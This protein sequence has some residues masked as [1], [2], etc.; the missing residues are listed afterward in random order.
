MLELIAETMGALRAESS[1]YPAWV[2]IWMK[3]MGFSFLAGILFVLNKK[4]A[5]WF[6][7][8]AILNIIGLVVGRLLFPDATR[9]AIGTVVHLLIWAP[10]LWAVWR[11]AI[12]PAISSVPNGWYERI[13]LA[14]LYWASLLMA[15]SL[16]FDLNAALR[17]L[18]STIG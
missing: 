9:A 5:R 10:I 1:L 11:T 2:Q 16:L 13:Y 4:A 12:R 8:A 14:W 6:V 15:I 17:W 7:A 18:L 3:V